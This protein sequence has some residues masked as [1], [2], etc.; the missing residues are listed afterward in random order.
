M[1][2]KPTFNGE[3]MFPSDYIAAE[4]CKGKDVTLTISNVTVEDLKVKGGSKEQKFILYFKGTDK[5]L[6]LNKTNAT[7]IAK[8]YGGEATQWVG[9][10]ITIFPTQCQ[11][12]GE[13][14]TCIRIREQRPGGR[15]NVPPPSGD[16]GKRMTD[17]IEDNKPSTD[18]ETP[19]LTTSGE[20][21]SDDPPSGSALPGGGFPQSEPLLSDDEMATI[22]TEGLPTV[23]E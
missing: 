4:D 11:A 16:A 15:Q 18:G 17:Q 13:T 10:K 8:I 20:T 23:S 6:V 2:A 1:T 14:T 21:S 9:E 5:K 22:G 12:F 7:T 3:L 19:A